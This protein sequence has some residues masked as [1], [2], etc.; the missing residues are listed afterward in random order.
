MTRQSF[1]T[2]VVGQNVQLREGLVGMLRAAGF[3]VL[4]AACSVSDLDMSFLYLQQ[5]ILMIVTVGDDPSAAVE[6]IE[7]FKDTST[8]GS[9]VVVADRFRLNDVI[10][11]FQRVRKLILLRTRAPPHLSNI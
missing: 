3:Q 4:D 7:L 11:A 5:S 10:S 1:L 8:N 9:V 2:V 6:Q